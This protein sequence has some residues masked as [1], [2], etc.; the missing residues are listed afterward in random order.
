MK[1]MDRNSI[2]NDSRQPLRQSTSNLALSNPYPTPSPSANGNAVLFGQ[3]IAHVTPSKVSAG[4]KQSSTPPYDYEE[5][6]WAAS[7]AAS[8]FAASSRF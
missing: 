7:A 3:G 8:I 6:E 1:R 2:Q 5:N 4:N